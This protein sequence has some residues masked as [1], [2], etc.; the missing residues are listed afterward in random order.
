MT[1]AQH[2][3]FRRMSDPRSYAMPSFRTEDFMKMD[4]AQAKT[5]GLALPVL[6]STLPV[7][8]SRL[9]IGALSVKQTIV[10]RDAR[11]TAVVVMTHCILHGRRKLPFIPYRSFFPL[12]R[13]PEFFDT[14]AF[15]A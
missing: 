7:P 9:H 6:H 10:V 13:V 8:C 12:R 14:Q 1:V 3:A 4:L 15:D 11:I 2:A 5:P